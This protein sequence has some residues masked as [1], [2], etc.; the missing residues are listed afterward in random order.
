MI[1]IAPLHAAIVTYLL[2]R[3]IG[4][5][6]FIPI[7]I[8]LLQIPLQLVLAKIFALTRYVVIIGDC[9]RHTSFHTFVYRF[10]SA[11]QTDKRVRIMNEMITGIRVI[12]MYAWEYAFKRVV[13]AIRK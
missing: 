3:E 12:K 8:I 1:W 13:A 10:K 9:V 4:W 7:S 11:R 2:Y 5:V 6:A